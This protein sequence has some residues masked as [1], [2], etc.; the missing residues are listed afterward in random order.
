MTVSCQANVPERDNWQDILLRR[1]L[2]QIA[3]VCAAWAE[4]EVNALLE[5]TR[6]GS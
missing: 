2:V 1:E 6:E 4:S 5:S 3:A